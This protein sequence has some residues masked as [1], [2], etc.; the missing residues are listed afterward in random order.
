MSGG[1]HRNDEANGP[2]RP[3]ERETER[4]RNRESNQP[5][6]AAQTQR[7][8]TGKPKTKTK[9]FLTEPTSLEML[10]TVIPRSAKSGSASGMVSSEPAQASSVPGKPRCYQTPT[11]RVQFLHRW[12]SQRFCDS[13][14]QNCFS[15]SAKL[16]AQGI[17]LCRLIFSG[18][19]PSR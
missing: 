1:Q 2:S 12:S 15:L 9:T 19:W 13:Q 17:G 5:S 7:V 14:A 6:A 11:E 18:Y 3:G 16:P 8:C 4:S 10:S